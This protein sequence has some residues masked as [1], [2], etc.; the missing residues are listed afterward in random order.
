LHWK[1]VCPEKAGTDRLL[2]SVLS[3]IEEER[4]L[5]RKRSDK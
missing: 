3:S 4:R 5:K 2:T 1:K